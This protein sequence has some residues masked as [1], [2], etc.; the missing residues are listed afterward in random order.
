MFLTTK[1]R[2]ILAVTGLLGLGFVLGLAIQAPTVQRAIVGPLEE[3]PA[4]TRSAGLAASTGLD[5]TTATRKFDCADPGSDACRPVRESYLRYLEAHRDANSEYAG[6]EQS[7][8][9]ESA[10]IDSGQRI[11]TVY[12]GSRPSQY[13]VG[14]EPD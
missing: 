1:Q 10:E 14:R 5:R 12:H 3:A 7:A 8:G 4:A 13:V 6:S 2:R 9:S 11:V